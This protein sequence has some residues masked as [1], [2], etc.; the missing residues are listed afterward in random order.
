MC[1]SP[2]DAVKT[3]QHEFILFNVTYENYKISYSFMVNNLNLWRI[4][5]DF[6]KKI[7]YFNKFS[8][9]NRSKSSN[10]VTC[11]R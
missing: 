11:G 3:R 7:Q 5:L 10:S 9:V 4:F 8:S 1:G 6:Q 2:D